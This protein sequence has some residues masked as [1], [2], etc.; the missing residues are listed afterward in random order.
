MTMPPA[1][2]PNT[3]PP[4]QAPPMPSPAMLPG[5]AAAAPS[6]PM[7][8]PAPAASLPTPGLPG[9][10]T[11]PPQ[12]PPASAVPPQPPAMPAGAVPPVQRTIPPK[13]PDAS[14]SGNTFERLA[15]LVVDKA[16]DMA[17]RLS[18]NL[19]EAPAGAQEL[20]PEQVKAM[21]Y[22]S[23]TGSVAKA[24][25]TF[26][27][28]HDQVLTQTGDHNQAETQALQAAYPYRAQLAQV[29]VAGAER[30]VQLAEQLRKT[31]DGDQAPDSTQVAADHAAHAT[32]VRQASGKV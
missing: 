24:D 17:K 11:P 23:P 16:A 30:Q 25:A 20:T 2:G 7:P 26:W 12:V 10:G 13:Q 21:W 14:D 32:R 15:N 1:P 27:Q 8:G 3:A 22:F 5:P 29:G 18:Q 6:L 19:N 9:P 31:V 28:V 4:P